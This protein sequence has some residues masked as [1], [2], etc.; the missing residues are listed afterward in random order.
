MAAS[1]SGSWTRCCDVAQ[2]LLPFAL[3]AFCAAFAAVVRLVAN[4]LDH[5]AI[6]LE[7]A[8][9][10]ARS[11][12]PKAS[13][14]SAKKAS[15]SLQRGLAPA[16]SAK[17]A[18]G[19]RESAE[20]DE[21]GRE[22][23]AFLNVAGADYGYGGRLDDLRRTQF[24]RLRGTV[25]LDHAGAALYSEQQV[26]DT[27]AELTATLLSNPHSQH[28]R[29]LGGEGLD[30]WAREATL[31]M[32]AAQ[33]GE[34]ECVLTSG[35]TAGLRLLA[36]AFPWARGSRFWYT[37]DNHNS[38]LGIR[39]EAAAR[40]ATANAVDVSRDASGLWAAAPRGQAITRRGSA[41]AGCADIGHCHSGSEAPAC[42]FAFPQESNFS[43]VKYNL[44]VIRQLG[45]G[46]GFADDADGAT[47]WFTLLDAAKGA[48]TCP[49]D[50]SAVQPDF[51]VLSFYKIFGFPTGLGALLIRKAAAPVLARRY[52]G[53]GTVEAAAAD[54]DVLRRRAGP[55]GLED[56]TPNFLALPALR[57]GLRML[58]GLGGFPAVAA[59]AGSLATHLA[60]WLRGLRHPGTG[61]PAAVL[62]GWEDAARGSGDR[63]GW[64][65]GQGPTVAF[66]L[67]RA[68][69][70][71]VG[72]R[73]V[74]KLAALHGIQM[75]AGCFCNPGAC[76]AFL[77]ISAAQV[78]AHHAA[79]HVCWD[80][81]D[82]ADGRP[83]GA[84]RASFGWSS[85]FADVAALQRVIAAYFLSPPESP[86]VGSIPEAA[87]GNVTQAASAQS[88]APRLASI[89]VYPI[90]SCAGMAPPA[91]WPLGPTGLLYDRHWVLLA[92]DGAVLTQKRA[93]QMARLAPAIDLRARI[94]RLSY[95]GMPAPLVLPLPAL[96]GGES[97]DT[98]AEAGAGQR[99]AVPVRMCTATLCAQPHAEGAGLGSGASTA[100]ADASARWLTAALG[101]RCRLAQEPPDASRVG[102]D[103]ARLSYAN[104]AQML[105]VSTASLDDLNGR[106]PRSAGSI[107][108]ARFRPNLVLDARGLRPYAEDGWRRL[109]LGSA[110]LA[111]A[112]PCQ[113]CGMVCVDPATGERGG[114]EPLRTLA[115]YRRAPGGKIT[116]GVLL[117][118]A[119]SERRGP[120]A[121]E[122]G[123]DEVGAEAPVGSDAHWMRRRFPSVLEVGAP[124]EELE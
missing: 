114:L 116:F 57:H 84:V 38:V 24:T 46:R 10:A 106:L 75:R 62:Y 13:V 120:D 17:P 42:L 51:V 98:A 41:D 121:P 55:A 1:V 93:P 61:S 77:G 45:K 16:A 20:A 7:R 8:V 72:S 32:C 9:A 40:G 22:L 91:A 14:S 53:G 30:V 69:G 78:A 124:L 104:E 67:L 49:P 101:V 35:A 63:G 70:S 76:A 47:R 11:A 95:P 26:R 52:F 103:G 68:D 112:G 74:E 59:H 27:T 115:A 123:R 90:K 118:Q 15:S 100:G 92:E 33:P 79:G 117:S 48:A 44:D 110:V 102:I 73:E 122:D 108:A 50:L 36:E 21:T 3:A 99:T 64:V 111:S 18:A 94:M 105:A 87:A 85:S 86:S 25:Y 2:P 80:D 5:L 54:A 43:G 83:L 97:W 81:N 65:T 88:G 82:L 71:Y 23:S 113:R 12:D 34:Y 31:H 37:Q 60:A 107:T 19:G 6:T 58:E 109:R 119:Q 28:E 96:P 89:H 66:N 39:E 56:G 4:A 29:L